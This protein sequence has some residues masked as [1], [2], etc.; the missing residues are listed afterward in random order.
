MKALALSL[1]IAIASTGAAG[2]AF[3]GGLGYP[4]ATGDLFDNG[5][6]N[7]DIANVSVCNDDT[8]VCI[9]IE[10]VGYQS[11]TKYL[12]FFDTVDGGT[13]SNAWGRPINLTREIDRYIGSWVDAPD[14]NA[15]NW[16]WDGG[17]WVLDSTTSNDQ[18]QTDTNR[19]SF[20]VSLA[21]LGLGIGDSF[22]FDVAT[23]GGGGSDPG[24]DLRPVPGVHDRAGSR[25][26]R[27]ARPRGPR[28]ATPSRL[29][30]AA[31]RRLFVGENDRRRSRTGAAVVVDGRELDGP[32]RRGIGGAGPPTHPPC[33]ASSCAQRS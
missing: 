24:V 7:L 8:T 29:N 33:I 22:R 12:L 18:T 10:T 4:D 19:V 5:F 28:L 31:T 21:W 6:T 14:N 25:C 1:S 2:G 26:G 17:A 20:Y 27:P 11:W 3:G 16:S 13:T 23:S 9:T 30:R 15:Q 32:S